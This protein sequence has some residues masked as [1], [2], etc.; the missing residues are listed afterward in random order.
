MLFKN[1]NRNNLHL[2]CTGRLG[3]VWNN[4]QYFAGMSLIVH[5]F[6]FKHT[7][8]FTNNTFGT[9]NFYVGLNFMKRK[10]YRNE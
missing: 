8:L 9:L 2:N 1:F 6:N 4:T 7:N 3:V 5:T 10:Q